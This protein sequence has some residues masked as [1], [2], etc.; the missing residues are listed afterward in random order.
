VSER[1][2]AVVLT[3]FFLLVVSLAGFL[4]GEETRRQ[5]MVKCLSVAARSVPW[6]LTQAH[7]DRLADWCTQP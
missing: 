7:W 5:E 4:A 6:E 1:G 3:V 2:E